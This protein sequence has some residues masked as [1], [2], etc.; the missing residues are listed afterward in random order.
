MGWLLRWRVGRRRLLPPLRLPAVRRGQASQR[1]GK[2]SLVMA[3]FILFLEPLGLGIGF[4][5][6]L[7]AHAMVRIYLTIN[8]RISNLARI[9]CSNSRTKDIIYTMTC[10]HVPVC[11]PSLP[12]Y[13]AP[14]G[15]QCAWRGTLSFRQHSVLAS[16]LLVSM[17]FHSFIRHR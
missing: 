1:G 11:S 8:I 5:L 12:S 2:T 4:G 10:V 3:D 16:R 17:G 7:A 14:R 13:R 9:R 15:H 6:R